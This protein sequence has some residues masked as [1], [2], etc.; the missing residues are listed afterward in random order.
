MLEIQNINMND[1]LKSGRIKDVVIQNI[2]KTEDIED[3]LFTHCIFFDFLAGIISSVCLR[4]FYRGIEIS[5][6]MYA[7]LFSQILFSTTASFL[8]FL[9]M[10]LSF[11]EAIPC[12]VALSINNILHFMY[13]MACIITWLAIA[14]LRYYL[15]TNQEN[16]VIDLPK[17]RK[18]ALTCTWAT[19]TVIVSMRI[20]FLVLIN[21]NIDIFPVNGIFILFCYSVNFTYLDILNES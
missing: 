2:C 16:D 9:L 13:M 10:F 19:N 5:H 6:P 21:Y 18:I 15:L 3:I 1:S 17:L 11:I 14:I 20:I 12:V 8:S 4:Q 7:I